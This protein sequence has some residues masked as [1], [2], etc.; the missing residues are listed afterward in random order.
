MRSLALPEVGLWPMLPNDFLPWQS[1]SGYFRS[2][3]KSGLWPK[4]HEKLDQEVGEA[5]AMA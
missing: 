3:K 1:V 4:V 2:W 5:D